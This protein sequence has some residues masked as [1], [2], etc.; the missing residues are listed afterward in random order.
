MNLGDPAGAEFDQIEAGVDHLGASN[1]IDGERVAVM[2][3]SY[4]GYL[5]AWAVARG[6]RFRGGI[7]IA[8]IS[9]LQSCWGTA[10]NTPFF[11]FLC[12]G[13]PLEQP[14]RYASRSPVTIVSKASLPALILHGEVDQ[15][16][17]LGQAR[18]LYTSL[19]S[20]NVAVELVAYPG[21]GHQV[22]SIDFKRDQRRRIL[23]FLRDVM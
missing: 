19:T 1:V 2:G 15:C 8:G 18:E 14:E 7:V 11:E 20:A 10:N 22:Q 13:T 3:A 6:G 12:D 23:E 4:G 5:T 9:N 21:E 16:V 17:P